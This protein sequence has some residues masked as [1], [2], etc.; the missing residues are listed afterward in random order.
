MGNCLAQ[1]FFKPEAE[2]TSAE[3]FDFEIQA[4]IFTTFQ[5]KSQ[6]K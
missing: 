1:Y 5:T 6:F 4:V 3:P 2:N